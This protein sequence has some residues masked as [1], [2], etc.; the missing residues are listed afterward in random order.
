M[1]IYIYVCGN[2]NIYICVDISCRSRYQHVSIYYVYIYVDIL[3]VYIRDV[4]YI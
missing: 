3:C 1:C 2:L 4:Y